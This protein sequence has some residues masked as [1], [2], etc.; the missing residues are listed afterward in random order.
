MTFNTDLGGPQ[1]WLD[2]L[3]GSATMLEF[4]VDVWRLKVPKFPY[5]LELL[6]E[7]RCKLKGFSPDVV[8]INHDLRAA[9][10]VACFCRLLGGVG[11]PASSINCTSND[12]NGGRLPPRRYSL[13]W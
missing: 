4:D 8:Y 10:L 1:R 7:L 9:C 13:D 6:Q 11:Q 12:R 2:G 5:Y 3:L